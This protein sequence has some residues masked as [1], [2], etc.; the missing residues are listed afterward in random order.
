MGSGGSEVVVRCT[1][2]GDG[3]NG[4][5]DGSGWRWR[6]SGSLHYNGRAWE[7]RAEARKVSQA[8]IWA[9]WG[10]K[11]VV[12]G[13]ASSPAMARGQQRFEHCRGFGTAVYRSGKGRRGCLGSS[14]RA[15]AAPG[16]RLVE[17]EWHGRSG[18]PAVDHRGKRRAGRA[19]GGSTRC[20]G[21]L[22][23]AKP[24]APWWFGRGREGR[25]RCVAGQLAGGVRRRSKAGSR[26]RSGER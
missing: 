1:A 21:G 7:A 23:S 20:Q 15:R 3:A 26:E 13:E 12:H 24:G 4:G 14:G 11:A 25:A 5:G 8:S 10:W 17:G 2:R 19:L 16:Q 6:C 9:V 22:V 18:E